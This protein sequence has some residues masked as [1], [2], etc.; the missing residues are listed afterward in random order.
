MNSRNILTSGIILLA[1]GVM[2][3]ALL[4]GGVPE[5]SH[6]TQVTGQIRSLEKTT[7]KGGGLGAVRFSLST[8]SRYFH[9]ISK[10]GGIDSV[11]SA[12]GQAGHSEIG[13]LIDP[14]DSHSPP[15]ED[16][17]FYTVLEVRVGDK[18]IRPYAQVVES[19]DTDNFVGAWLGY[20]S[21][22]TGIMLLFIHF[23]KRRQHA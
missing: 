22:A 13:I 19:W 15:L 5:R 6:L 2:V 8:D 21:A 4:D 14:A 1:F 16:R 9:Y 18:M 10:A 23:L 20:G 11:W 17:A 12:L 7:S 3:L